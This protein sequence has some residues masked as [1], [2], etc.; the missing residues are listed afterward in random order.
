MK[1]LLLIAAFA[2]AGRLCAQDLTEYRWWVND[3]P[4]TL[5]NTPIAATAD[6]QVST[7]L[8]LP[9]LTRDYN[10]ITVQFKDSDGRY[11]VPFTTWYSK[12][13]GAVNGYEY[14]IDDAITSSSTGAI[15]PN[16][17][18]DLIADLPTGTTNG[19]HVFTIRFSSVNGTWTVPLTTEFSFFNR[20]DELPG[21]SDLLLFPNPVTDELGL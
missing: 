21:I 11:S 2:A 18:V 3:D 13:T 16:T 17:V 5:V 6:V 14:W 10:T 9:A 12:G 4:A 8:D 15:G 19:A 7:A 1:R 20:V